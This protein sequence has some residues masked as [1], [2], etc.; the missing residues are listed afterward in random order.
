VANLLLLAAGLTMVL[1]G[2]SV[3]VGSV[4]VLC[5]RYGMPPDVLAVTI[6]AFGTSLPELAA[7]AVAASVSRD[8]EQPQ[9][10]SEAS[11]EPPARPFVRPLPSPLLRSTA[12]AGSPHVSSYRQARDPWS[13]MSPH[14]PRCRARDIGENPIE[15]LVVPPAVGVGG[16]TDNNRGVRLQS[17]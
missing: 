7:T 13:R 15:L 3:L 9:A 17:G 2:S 8:M 10:S 12:P 1:F 5:I 16:I 4:S 11:G 14:N 6:V